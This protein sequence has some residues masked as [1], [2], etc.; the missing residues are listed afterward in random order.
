MANVICKAM[1]TVVNAYSLIVGTAMTWNELLV[2]KYPKTTGFITGVV[3]G[4]IILK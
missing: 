2:D 3:I 1:Y 4:R